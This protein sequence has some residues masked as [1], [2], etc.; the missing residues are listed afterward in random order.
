MSLVCARAWEFYPTGVLDTLIQEL[1][2]FVV[3]LGA[4]IFS[5]LYTV[6][7]C[8]L[9][10]FC[11]KLAH[12]QHSLIR[13]IRISSRFDVMLLLTQLKHSVSRKALQKN[14]IQRHLLKN[15]C[16]FYTFRGVVLIRNFEKILALVILPNKFC[17]IIGCSYCGIVNLFIVLASKQILI[18]PFF[19]LTI[20]MGLI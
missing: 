17:I 16:T 14:N 11:Y 1:G 3:F 2:T 20:T 10:R 15:L 7:N 5:C 9:P 19:F 6:L 8:D 12:H 4:L 18:S 13:R